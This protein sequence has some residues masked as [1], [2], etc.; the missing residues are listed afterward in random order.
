MSNHF[1]VWNNCFGRW[2]SRGHCGLDDVIS[3]AIVSIAIV[4]IAVVA[5]V[6]AAAIQG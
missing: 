2:R 4:S 1:G 3:I 6:I 5:I